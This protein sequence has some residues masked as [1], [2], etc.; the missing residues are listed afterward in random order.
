M[1]I[2][3]KGRYALRVLVDM[4]EHETGNFLPLRDVANRQD[5]SEKYLESVV[6]LLVRGGILEGLRG[7]GGGY[8]LRRPPDQIRVGDVLRL[9]EGNLSP[10]SC[11][12][13]DAVPCEHAANCRTLPLWRGLDRV[14]SDY[15]DK[16]TIADL[17]RGHD[18]GN[19]YVI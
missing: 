8:C 12:G 2:S 10:V 19:D 9:C 7:K 18:N 13:A 5:I 3:T 15:L 4:A 16:Y 1:L 11:L 17:M 6:K 14:I